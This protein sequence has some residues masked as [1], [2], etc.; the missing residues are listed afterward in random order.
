MRYEMRTSFK[1]E[2]DDPTKADKAGRA[3][4]VLRWLHEFVPTVADMG[5]GPAHGRWVGDRYNETEVTFQLLTEYPD[6]YAATADRLRIAQALVGK[7]PATISTAPVAVSYDLLQLYDDQELGDPASPTKT[8]TRP[9]K[10]AHP[11]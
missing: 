5:L 3:D 1:L 6:V 10:I 9:G 2:K 4:R 7:P 11:G 8:I